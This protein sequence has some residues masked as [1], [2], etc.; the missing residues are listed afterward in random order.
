MPFS[1]IG[2]TKESETFGFVIGI[3]EIN[4]FWFCEMWGMS[5]SR[6]QEWVSQLMR[7]ETVELT[8]TLGRRSKGEGL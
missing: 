6:L 2:Q 3:A 5:G 4:S 1:E 7:L 8:P